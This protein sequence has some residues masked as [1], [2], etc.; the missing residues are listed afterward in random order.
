MKKARPQI[1]L[2]PLL[3]IIALLLGGLYFAARSGANPYVYNNDF[4]VYYYAAR[5]IRAGRTP[6]E[7]SLTAWTPYLYL[8]VLAELL[9]PLAWLPLRV[10]AYVWFLISAVSVFI[11]ARLS[12]Q[13]TLPA[14]LAKDANN[15]T[16]Q[17]LII[18]LTLLGLT[19]FILDNFDYG[20]VNTVVAGLTVAHL[21]C[22]AK[23]KKLAALA[24]LGLAAAIKLTPLIF[25]FYHLARRRVK[26]ALACAALFVALSALSFAP[27]GGRANDA[28]TT[29][30]KRTLQNEQGF[31]L[32]Y[33]GNQSLR[34][35]VE[36]LQGNEEAIEASSLMTTAIGAGLLLLGLGVASRAQKE[37][38]ASA[39]VFCLAVL[40][41]PLA[42]KQ[43]FVLLILPVTYLIHEA[44]NEKEKR[45]RYLL[46][47]A[48]AIALA[49]FNLTSL[50]LIG[51]AAAEWSDAHSLIFVGSMIL[52]IGSL[53]RAWQTS[54][55]TP[56]P[57]QKLRAADNP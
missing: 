53:I 1:S 14:Q 26:F 24:A 52:Y 41:S 36:R 47:G 43:H 38:A 20:Q 32:A 37:V 9:V 45:A 48:L 10:A 17:N 7:N 28:F 55:S 56:Q 49:F 11:A 35:V 23:N 51:Q 22:Y 57:V 15:Q 13:L 30:F 12:A 3:F 39:S 18:L 34:A 21:Y 5:E 2:L 29:F 46:I 16:K 8:P 25:I 4:N 6:Y 44:L 50:K 31:N 33:H 54:P 27:F 40:L 19:R 42:W